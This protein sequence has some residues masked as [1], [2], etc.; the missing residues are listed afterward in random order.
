MST[1]TKD[2]A[3]QAALTGNWKDAIK[4]NEELRKVE[5]DD[6]D[7]LNR[8][9]YAYAKNGQPTHAKKIFNSVLALDPYNTIA[10]KNITLLSHAPRS[11]G[12]STSIP[13]A[14]PSAFLEDPGKTKLVSC[15]NL[16]TAQVIGTLS[17]G[18]T[19][20]IKSKNHTVEL[21]SAQNTYLAA[22]PDDISFKLIKLMAA[23]NTYQVVVKAVEKN[24]LTV[25]VREL[26]RGKR[27]ANQPSFIS[28]TRAIYTPFT[29]AEAKEEEKP[30]TVATG[31]E[32]LDEDEVKPDDTPAG[33]EEATS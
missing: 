12:N 19:V 1:I 25:M 32:D 17:P 7:T 23:G 18:Q 33:T 20:S 9:A 2:A 13:A 30:V 8:L 22:L 16:A 26:T 14:P 21:R 6:I 31:E 24:N 3:I 27:F 10:H 11:K 15:I 5:K 28:S 4:I 29:P